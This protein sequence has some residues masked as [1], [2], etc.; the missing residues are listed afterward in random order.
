MVESAP[1]PDTATAKRRFALLSLA[2]IGWAAVPLAA[3]FTGG[4]PEGPVK[5]VLLA[6]WALGVLALAVLQMRALAAALGGGS[7]GGNS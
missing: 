1:Q 3:L 4:L 2:V 7:T 6:V 5:F